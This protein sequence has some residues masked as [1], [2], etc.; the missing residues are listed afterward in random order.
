MSIENLILILISWI[1]VFIGSREIALAEVEL[2][3]V[4]EAKREQGEVS[5]R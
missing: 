2:R 3:R 4:R 5:G 1:V